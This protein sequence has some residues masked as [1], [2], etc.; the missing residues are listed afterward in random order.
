MMNEMEGTVSKPQRS[1]V[2]ILQAQYETLAAM[3]ANQAAQNRRMVIALEEMNHR[4]A[5]NLIQV[6]VEDV[7]MPFIAL[8]GLMLKIAVASIPAAIIF[9]AVMTIFWFCFAT[10]GLASLLSLGS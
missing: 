9:V 3:S 1:P 4:S 6:K 10:M 2:E 7:N 5:E 8:V